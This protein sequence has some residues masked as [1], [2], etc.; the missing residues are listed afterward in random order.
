MVAATVFFRAMICADIPKIAVENPVMHG[1]GVERVGKK[2]DQT[3]QPYQFGHPESKRTCL[4][5]K[6]L[7]PLVPTNIL[8]KPACG[9]WDNQCPGG[10]NKLGP[11]PNRAKLRSTTYRGI[12][13]AMA[14]QWGKTILK[15]GNVQ[16]VIP[17]ETE[18][19]KEQAIEKDRL[20]S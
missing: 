15:L 14:D 5:L 4:W 16:V 13:E 7:P 12:A 17:F 11:G 19:E 1:H 2:Q 6:G 10:Q 18:E 3:I 20:L 8:S 9:Y